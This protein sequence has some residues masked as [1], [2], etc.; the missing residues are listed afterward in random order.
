MAPCEH[1]PS[2]EFELFLDRRIQ[3]PRGFGLLAGLDT[4]V[5]RAAPGKSLPID[6]DFGRHLVLFFGHWAWVCQ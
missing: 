3:D 1:A 4:S 2:T 6:F 5:A